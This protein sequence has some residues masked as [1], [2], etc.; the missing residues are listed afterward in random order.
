MKRASRHGHAHRLVGEVDRALLHHR[1]D[2]E[3]PRVVI[4]QDVDRKLQL[5]V[6]AP[7]EPAHAAR[8]LPSSVDDDA[9]VL[10]PELVLVEAAPHGVLLDEEDVLGVALAE[11][12]RCLLS[13]MDGTLQPPEPIRA[14]VDG[15]AGVD[16]GESPDHRPLVRGEE[17][18]LLAQRVD[19]DF[20]VLDDRVGLSSC[21]S[22]V[23]A[24]G[25]PRV[26]FVM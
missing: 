10:L 2:V 22:K 11:L 6:Q 14:Q 18:Q 3:A 16:D 25:S 13:T 5:L 9:L 26:C 7:H 19:G 4:D 24:F 8:R 12:D 1:V 21:S 23:L 20:E 15:V 17:V